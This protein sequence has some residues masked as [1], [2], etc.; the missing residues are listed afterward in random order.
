MLCNSIK[1]T[2]THYGPDPNPRIE[3]LLLLALQATVKG[4]EHE[5]WAQTCWS[6]GAVGQAA[7]MAQPWAERHLRQQLLLQI[8][9]Q[10][11]AI[12]CA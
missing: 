10:R 7:T 5:V 8:F 2:Q 4:P 12:T 9:Q 1:L 6:A 11:P 3:R